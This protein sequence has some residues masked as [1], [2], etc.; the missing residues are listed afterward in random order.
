MKKVFFVTKDKNYKNKN[1]S[2]GDKI[3][4]WIKVDK[5]VKIFM[6]TMYFNSLKILHLFVILFW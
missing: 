1:K 5:E 2:F 3:S 4:N 6:L